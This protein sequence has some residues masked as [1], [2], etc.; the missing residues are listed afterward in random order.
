MYIIAFFSDVYEA[1]DCLAE[2][3]DWAETLKIA[4]RIAEPIKFK[5]A[6]IINLTE[7]QAGGNFTRYY[8]YN[9]TSK[10]W[11]YECSRFRKEMESLFY[12]LPKE[13]QD[14]FVDRFYG[15]IEEVKQKDLN[16]AYSLIVRSIEK[17]KNVKK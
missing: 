2:I 12:S 10:K 15:K 16:N 1:S 17:N 7:V 8:H 5:G 6:V 9:P 3:V 14:F 4:K 11:E 13:Q